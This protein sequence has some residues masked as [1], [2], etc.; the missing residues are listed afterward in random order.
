MK[1]VLHHCLA[2]ILAL[3]LFAPLGAMAQQGMSADLHREAQQINEMMQQD[4]NEEA[5]R[6]LEPLRKRGNLNSYEKAVLAQLIGYAHAG[7]GQYR[8]AAAAFQEALSFGTLPAEVSGGLSLALV[9]MYIELRD[10]AQ[11]RTLIE[12]M[13]ADGHTADSDFLAVAAYVYY[14]LK[15]Y[16][17]AERH[18]LQAINQADEAKENW[19]QILLAIYRAQ[20]QWPKA[21]ALLRDVVARYPDN[22]NYWQFLSYT[23]YEQ[24]RENESLAT[25]MLAYRM[26]LIEGDE[27]ERLIGMHANAGIPEKAARLLEEWTSDGSLEVNEE[28]LSLTGRLWLLARE[29]SKAM[30][31]IGRAAEASAT[32][33]SDLLLGKLHYEDERWEDA[34][35]HFQAALAKGIEDEDTAQIQ[36]L[37]GVSAYNAGQP[38]IA[39]TAL[40]A[41]SRKREYQNHARYWLTRL[42]EQRG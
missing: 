10:F 20:Q 13:L 24:G 30:V 42:A 31:A 41:A 40:E 2:G 19:Y 9:Q 7:S 3:A 15:D 23:M 34:L 11:A 8:Q 33:D 12:R 27:L 35:K 25:L 22:F 21:E 28:R 1:P 39:R 36:L 26:G 37:L 38:E 18:A 17:T 6:R 32:G 4:R 16:A 5:I 29:R 14:E